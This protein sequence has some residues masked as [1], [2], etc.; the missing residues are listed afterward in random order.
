MSLSI[1]SLLINIVAIFVIFFT[2]LY[3][4]FTRNFDFW[5]KR[6]VPYAKPL[7]FVGNLKGAILQT[8][9]IGQ[10]LKQLY[11]E[12]KAKPCV[13][14]FSFDQPS[15]LII[16][17]D[18][19]KY[20]LVKDAKNFINRVQTADEKTD[21]LT[22]KAVFALKDKK[23]RHIRL[24]MT[25]IFTT[26][27]MKKMFY[28]VEKCAKELTLQVDKKIRTDE[29]RLEVKDWMAR[30]T[31]DVISSCA[32][33]IESNTLVN[34]DGKFRSYL[35][36][37]TTYTT[38]KSFATLA[39]S[40]APKFQSLFKLKILDDDI[41]TFMRNTVWSTVRYREANNVDRK[42]FLDNMMELR[43]KGQDSNEDNIAL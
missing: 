27:K 35:R 39:I 2:L 19:V 33:G 7:P 23:W 36:R 26:G 38:L 30:Y 24:G 21:P 9:D 4:Y 1:Y 20:I 14:F 6:S 22:A 40:F 11:D 3:L 32:F 15:L 29:C 42:D 17:P 25:P 16:D 13:G 10:N 41:V 8:V 34:P 28:L 5:K 43:K 31:T 18:L 12:H 37:F